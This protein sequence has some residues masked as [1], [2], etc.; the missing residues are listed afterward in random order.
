MTKGNVQ[1]AKWLDFVAF[2][3]F[4]AVLTMAGV[5]FWGV[6]HLGS[7]PTVTWI[8]LVVSG[9][10]LPLVLVKLILSL[11]KS[12]ARAEYQLLA[13]ITAL[14]PFCAVMA[15]AIFAGLS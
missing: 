3:D 6:H 14:A 13:L 2:A 10:L 12:F 7:W 4:G 5:A 9:L 8:K 15:F 11:A 1:H